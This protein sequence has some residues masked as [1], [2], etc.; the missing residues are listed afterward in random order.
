MRSILFALLAISAHAAPQ[1]PISSLPASYTSSS[2]TPATTTS[3]DTS[4]APSQTYPVLSLAEP[5]DNCTCGYSI[6]SL[7]GAYYPF[8][9]SFT[10]SSLADGPMTSP[11]DLLQYGLKINDGKHA[12]AEGINGAQCWGRYRNVKIEEGDLVLTVPGGQKLS[13]DMD[14]AEITHNVSTFGGVFQ[15]EAT[16][17]DVAGTCEAFWLNHTIADTYA[18]EVDIDILTGKLQSDGIYY[19]NW[20]PFGNPNDPSSL[21]PDYTR[22]APFPGL[23]TRSPT[24]SYNNYTIVWLADP[25]GQNATL[26]YYNG[27]AQGNPRGNLPAHAMEYNINAWTNGDASWSAG[28]PTADSELRVKSILLYYK[29]ETVKAIG[30]LSADCSSLDVCKI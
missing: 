17:S 16:L 13:A 5:A 7:G 3:T 10:P 27:E 24:S 20:P 4:P 21:V 8:R 2:S 29:T 11:N 9:Y 12:G 6:Q 1:G 26:R 25:L 28:P 18:D 22:V 15:A 23:A 14:C 30:D 19:V